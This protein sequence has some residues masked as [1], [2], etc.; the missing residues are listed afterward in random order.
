MNVANTEAVAA[1]A[2]PSSRNGTAE[3][4][5]EREVIRSALPAPQKRLLEEVE[6]RHMGPLE[7][8]A[9]RDARET[10]GEGKLANRAEDGDLGYLDAPGRGEEDP[11]REWLRVEAAAHQDEETVGGEGGRGAAEPRP[12][13]SAGGAYEGEW[14]VPPLPVPVV[15]DM[16]LCTTCLKEPRCMVTLPCAHLCVCMGCSART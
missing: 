1:H 2:R 5:P 14:G 13:L 8:A 12:L 9:T 7:A 6:D 4:V 15:E 11:W 16:P 10:G 3:K